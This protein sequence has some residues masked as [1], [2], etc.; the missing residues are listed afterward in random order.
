MKCVN[1]IIYMYP[2]LLWFSVWKIY[3]KIKKVYKDRGSD[4][5]QKWSEKLI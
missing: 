4:D 2:R 3:T 5:G 1:F